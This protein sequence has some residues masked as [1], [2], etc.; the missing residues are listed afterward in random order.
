[1]DKDDIARRQS[2]LAELEVGPDVSFEFRSVKVG[3]GYF[4]SYHDSLL[5]EVAVTEAGMR[6]EIEGYDGVCVDTMSDSGVSVLR[7]ILNIPVVGPGRVSFLT[8]LMLGRRFSVLTLWGAWE[9]GYRVTLRELGLEDRCVSIRWPEG[10]EPDLRTLLE[11]KAETVLPK[12]VKAGEECIR[13]GADVI[14][15]GSTSM[16]EAHAYLAGHL[17]VPVLNP[18][19]LSYKLIESLLSLGLRQSRAAYS[20]PRGPRRELFEA[21]ITAAAK[22]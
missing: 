9:S 7:S 16:H 19:P 11:G 18:G 14:C 1:L 5:A 10:V 6:A 8:A 21:M 13:D 20:E 22:I 15:L 3:P 4:D 17:P 2:Q 12:L